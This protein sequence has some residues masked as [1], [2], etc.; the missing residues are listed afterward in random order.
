MTIRTRAQKQWKKLYDEQK[1]PDRNFF[2]PKQNEYREIQAECP[3]WSHVRKSNPRR[4]DG[5]ARSLIFRRGYLYSEGGSDGTL[6]SGLLFVC[7]QRNIEKGFEHIKK[8]F[9]NNRNFPVPELRRSFSSVEFQR[10]SRP[11]QSTINGQL[12]EGT[13]SE[14]QH[15]RSKEQYNDMDTLNTGREGL[16]G[17]SE[18]G[19]YPQGQIPVTV[20]L[21]GGYYFIPPIPKKR[22]SE[23]SEQF[24]Y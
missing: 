22:I 18:L 13:V 10:R 2:D 9:L 19:L 8:H 21:G 3:V 15:I 17:P 5:A 11:S 1:D 23:I 16:S 24:F 4:A 7:F 12:S 14:E 20:T 6:S